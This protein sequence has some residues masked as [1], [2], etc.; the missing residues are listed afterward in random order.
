[1]KVEYQDMDCQ[2]IDTRKNNKKETADIKIAV[3]AA[4][5]AFDNHADK[6]VI[7]M[8]TNDS[9]FGS[10][11]TKLRCRNFPVILICNKQAPER[12]SIHAE[13]VIQLSDILSIRYPYTIA[14]LFSNNSNSNSNSNSNQVPTQQ[15][16]GT[17]SPTDHTLQQEVI[18]TTNNGTNPTTT[19]GTTSVP[20]VPVQV[21]VVEFDEDDENYNN[22][23]HHDNYINHDR[24]DTMATI[25]ELDDELDDDMVSV[26]SMA[27]QQNTIRIHNLI[28]V[29]SELEQKEGIPPLRSLVGVKYSVKYPLTRI[30]GELKSI[31]AQAAEQGLIIEDGNNNCKTDTLSVNRNRLH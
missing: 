16:T 31:I 2:C 9:D 4:F 23:N 24:S 12:L 27:S 14:E 8:I 30:K 22:Y 25:D 17:H 26:V 3:D 13:Q 6:T 19:N 20:N 15:V 7:V 28:T 29:I 5:Y 18:N 11:L 1:M 21:D 10:L